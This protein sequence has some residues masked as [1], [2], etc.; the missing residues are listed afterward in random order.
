[1]RVH[2]ILN[3]ARMRKLLGETQPYLEVEELRGIVFEIVGKLEL[4]PPSVLL[5][6]SSSKAIYAVS[7][8]TWNRI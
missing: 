4:V 1:M 8:A 3:H 6:I 2:V 5:A 7:I